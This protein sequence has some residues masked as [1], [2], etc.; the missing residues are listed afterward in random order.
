[1]ATLVPGYISDPVRIHLNVR[2]EAAYLFREFQ[3]HPSQVVI[4]N[5][6]E[7]MDVKIE[8]AL[9]WGLEEWIL[10]FGELLIVKTP[11]KLKQILHDRIKGLHNIYCKNQKERDI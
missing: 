11:T 8:C 7:S 6:D 2:P 3:Y 10:G 1:M 5:D 9:G 4:E